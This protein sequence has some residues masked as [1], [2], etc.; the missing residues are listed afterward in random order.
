MSQ[1]VY[2]L[3]NASTLQCMVPPMAPGGGAYGNAS[4]PLGLAGQGMYIIVNT[5][6]NNRY[7]GISTDLAQ[8]FNTRMATVTEMGFSEQQMNDIWLFWGAAATQNTPGYLGNN[9]PPFVIVQDYSAPLNVNIDGVAINLEKLLIRFLLLHLG[10]GGT[11]SN[12]LLAWGPYVNPTAA[13]MTVTLNWP[14]GYF[15]TTTSS[16]VWHSG[17]AW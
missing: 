8:R 15:N 6:T 4:L 9:N 3:M 12:N 13:D 5:I 10:A 1:V 16:A 7:A 17:Q 11:V 2:N 14:A